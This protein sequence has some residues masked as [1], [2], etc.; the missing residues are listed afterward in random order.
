M[1]TSVSRP[2][3]LSPV[4]YGSWYQHVQEWWELSHTHPVL[5]LFYE[6]I[7]E[8]RPPAPISLHVTLRKAGTSQSLL[9]PTQHPPLWQPTDQP[10][11][12]PCPGLKSRSA[13]SA[14]APCA[15]LYVL[16]PESATRADIHLLCT[17]SASPGTTI[18]KGDC[19]SS[20]PK[21]PD[22]C[23][24]GSQGR[25]QSH[26]PLE[27]RTTVKEQGLRSLGRNGQIPSGLEDRKSVV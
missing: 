9:R 7:K 20:Q 24:Q 13:P 3:A 17:A 19:P 14:A 21:E 15:A 5:Y 25:R 11:W 1:P 12:I 22:L 4:C 23:D 27:K 6:D 10:S 8:V 18:M 26:L 2:S 16:T